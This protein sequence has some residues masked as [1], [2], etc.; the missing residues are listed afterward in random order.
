MTTGDN[1]EQAGM[2]GQRGQCIFTR[3]FQKVREHHDGSRPHRESCPDLPQPNTTTGTSTCWQIGRHLPARSA[4]RHDARNTQR[5]HY[6][7]DLDVRRGGATYR[8]GAHACTVTWSAPACAI[9][10]L[11]PGVARRCLQLWSECRVEVRGGRPSTCPV[12]AACS[13][14]PGRTAARP[15]TS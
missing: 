9:T 8:W 7:P 5:V 15:P 2:Q 3:G 1:S 11:L 13:S 14:V 10:T 4:P 12:M 6:T